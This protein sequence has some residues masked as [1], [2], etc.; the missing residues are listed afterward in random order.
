VPCCPAFWQNP[1]AVGGTGESARTVSWIER[2][3]GLV[4]RAAG[5]RLELAL[6]IVECTRLLKG[7]GDIHRRR[8]DNF[9]TLLNHIIELG[10]ESS[11]TEELAV[12]VRQAQELVL[13]NPEAVSLKGKFPTPLFTRR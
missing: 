4:E 1:F 2:W 12:T 10:L 3:L 13:Q 8:L 11:N 7:C 6:E 5:Q 9:Q